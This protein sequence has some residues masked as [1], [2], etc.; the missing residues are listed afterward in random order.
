MTDHKEARATVKAEKARAKALRPWWKRKRIIIPAVFIV[1]IVIASLNSS[2]DEK[3]NNAATRPVDQSGVERTSNNAVDQDNVQSTPPAVTPDD[4]HYQIGDTA[5][6]SGLNVT[7]HEVKDPFETS[8]PLFGPSDGHRYVSADI[9]LENSGDSRT[10][11]STVLGL[12][13]KDT[14]NRVWNVT[15]TADNLSGLDG[16]LVAGESRRG[17]AVFE[18]PVESVI[19]ELWI[20]GSLTASGAVFRIG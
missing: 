2:D 3:N 19:A 18:V 9:T 17:T 11:F 6:T 16:D 7:L 20:K 15:I 4:D 5:T 13:V 12:E 14:D 8:N 10:S 1:I